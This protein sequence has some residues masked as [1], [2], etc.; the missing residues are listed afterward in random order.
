MNGLV[1]DRSFYKVFFKLTFTI[2]LQNV[3]V[4]SVNLA[5][6]VMLG[7]FDENAMAGVALVNQLQFLLQCMVM[8][9]AEAALMFSSRSWGE[10][11]IPS[12]RKITNISVKC[13]FI[14]SF[15]LFSVPFPEGQSRAC[16]LRRLSPAQPG[17]SW[18]AVCPG[19]LYA[20]LCAVIT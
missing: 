14:L 9:L 5:D 16:W 6:N 7:R 11:D 18:T 15:C 19:C 4:H 13:G 20:V 10:K 2:A 3:I 17:H 8:G 1:K 12:I